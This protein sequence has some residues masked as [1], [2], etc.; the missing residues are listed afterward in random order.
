[1]SR[2]ITIV[3]NWAGIAKFVASV[4]SVGLTVLVL[5]YFKWGIAGVAVAITLPLTVMN[6]IYLPFLI[7]Q[8]VGL[9][10]RQY[11][12]SVAVGPVVHVFPFAICLVVARIIFD[13]A[14]LRGLVWGGLTGGVFLAVVYYRYVLPDRIRVKTRS[15]LRV[16]VGS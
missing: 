12:L 16:G 10:M 11:F 15:I 3:Q 5:G 13:T 1:M 7:R 14:P 6:V 9:D 8:R 2:P 4:F